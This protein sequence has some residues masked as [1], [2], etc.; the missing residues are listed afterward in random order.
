M[1]DKKYKITSN[2]VFKSQ[3]GAVKNLT[4]NASEAIK[5]AKGSKCE[6]IDKK[7]VDSFTICKINTT[8]DG[9]DYKNVFI[10]KGNIELLEEYKY[11]IKCKTTDNCTVYSLEKDGG[12]KASLAKGVQVKALSG[13]KIQ[14]NS[15]RV[16]VKYTL[17]KTTDTGWIEGKYLNEI[18]SDTEA[19]N[20]TKTT[21]EKQEETKKKNKKKKTQKETKYLKNQ[22][23][24]VFAVSGTEASDDFLFKT[25][26]VTSM[27]GI[28]G[29]P[30]QFMN[31]V[32]RRIHKNENKNDTSHLGRTYARHI[33]ADMPLL[34]LTPGKVKFLSGFTKKSK[35]NAITALSSLSRIDNV[36]E[37][38]S[39]LLE[40]NYKTNDRRYYT[41]GF[42]VANY[43]NY[44]NPMLWNCAIYLGI[45]DTVVTIGGY[46]KK[47][48]KFNWKKVS[49]KYGSYLGFNKFVGF[50]LDSEKSISQSFSN[51]TGASALADGINAISDT[52]RE[53][54]F[55][56]GNV[57]GKHVKIQNRDAYNDVLDS[58]ETVADKYLNGSSLF[59]N[60]AQGALTVASGGRLAFPEVWTDSSFSQ[61]YD[62]S[63]KLRTPD[64]DTL[65]WYL[66]ICVPMI[67]LIAM[68]A[69]R[70]LSGNGYASP[71][72]VRAFYK[73]LFNIDTGMIDQ[74][75]FTKGRDSAWNADGLP[76]EVDVTMSIKDMYNVLFISGLKSANDQNGSDLLQSKYILKNT[77][78][79]D[80]L[81]NLCGINVSQ[82][83]LSRTLE[84]YLN[85]TVNDWTSRST[86]WG[87]N[88][89]NDVMDGIYG[90]FSDIFR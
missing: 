88:L 58:V 37:A 14:N 81:S 49:T 55:L 1:A 17:N 83:E 71:F 20:T 23:K 10:R 13:S 65:S 68:A 57:I 64:C 15:T 60:L 6:L 77:G 2:Y 59:K 32:D 48:K 9:K 82:P 16:N 76:T 12:P 3:N 26:A 51:S 38:L 53:L 66:N 25:L 43:Y 63:M 62:I 67:H 72:L 73:G 24:N 85:L 39:S 33:M 50:Y 78:M 29:A 56:T 8:I 44:V 31:I 27:T 80:Y 40:S 34:L 30:Y 54:Q 75:S 47:L 11:N 84:M 61:S 21:K 90:T 45:G 42:D 87:S 5:G 22:I 7:T 41:F 18:A 28:Y 52:A 89:Q 86:R 79:M 69:P 46:K 74:L 70:Q 35:K 19:K 36:Q 4:T